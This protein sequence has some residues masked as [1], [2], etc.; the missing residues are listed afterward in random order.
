MAACGSRISGG[1]YGMESRG[2]RRKRQVETRWDTD[3]CEHE[4]EGAGREGD[5]SRGP[6]G[7]TGS[8]SAEAMV[9]EGAG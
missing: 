9:A 4:D 8:G 7:Q 1:R 5:C 6:T 2:W 3:G